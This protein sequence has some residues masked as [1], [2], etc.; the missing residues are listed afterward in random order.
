MY[1]KIWLINII[2]S[3]CSL[4]IVFKTI[5]VW[6][7]NTFI[8]NPKTEKTKKLSGPDIRLQLK[9][10]P[11]E[12]TYQIIS[13]RNLFSVDRKEYIPPKPKPEPIAD[14]Q[15]EI[16]EVKISGEKIVL[17]GVI[18]K[19]DIW[20]A[21]INNPDIR[22]EKDENPFLWVKKGDQI[23][24]LKVAEIKQ[25]RILFADG[26]Q[27]YAILLY[28]TQKQQEEKKQQREQKKVS[29]SLPGIERNTSN[30]KE[31]K[32]KITGL[33]QS[34]DKQ[35]DEYEIIDTPFGKIKRKISK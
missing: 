8:P 32:P 16:T 25:D 30:K 15:P 18:L 31:S 27:M 1:R 24:N 28:D 4:V 21:I 7:Q 20:K 2:L 5:G 9:Q 26:S 14:T 13:G 23:K 34:S 6:S 19:D 3:V 12:S 22:A 29:K 17:Y 10:M 11:P 35:E 33:K